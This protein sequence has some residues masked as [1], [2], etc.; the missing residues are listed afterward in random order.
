MTLLIVVRG[1][2]GE[3][4]E[5]NRGHLQR[6]AAPETTQHHADGATPDPRGEPSYHYVSYSTIM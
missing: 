4:Q 3:V 5:H 1:S 6:A 2:P